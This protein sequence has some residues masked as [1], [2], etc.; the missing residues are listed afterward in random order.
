MIALLAMTYCIGTVVRRGAG[1][2]SII[3]TLAIPFI[4]LSLLDSNSAAWSMVD[5]LPFF[6]SYKSF[7]LLDHGFAMGIID[8]FSKASVPIMVAVSAAW[9]ALFLLIGAYITKNKEV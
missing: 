9:T 5:T 6:S 4:A 2:V 8:V 1:V 3:I 7:W